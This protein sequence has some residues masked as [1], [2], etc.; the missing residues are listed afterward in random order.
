MT[1]KLEMTP[2]N[3]VIEEFAKGKMVIMVDD[4]DRE[5]EGDLVVATEHLT[6]EDIVFMIKHG[7]GLICASIS[8]E[9]AIELKLPP[10]VEENN[11][12]FSTPFTVTIDLAD[13]NAEGVTAESRAKT[14]RALV[15]SSVTAEQFV[16][17]GHV[18][19]LVANR[20]G[21][22]GR[23]G[24][25]EGSYD[26]ARIAGCAPSGVICEILAE[27]GT[28]ARGEELLVFAK[29]HD[30]PITS[31]Q[32]IIQYRIREEVIARESA[33]S[34]VI[35]EHGEFEVIVFDDDV[36][37]K[38][39]LALVKGDIADLQRSSPLVRVHSE[40]LT[41]DVFGSRRCD[42]GGQ[43][44]A[45]LKEISSAGAG[46]LLYL[47]QEGRGIGL[48]NKLRAYE[49]Q[50]QGRDTVDA[51][52]ELGFEA[53]QRDYAIAASML[54]S[55]GLHSVKLMTNNPK[56]IDAFTKYGIEVSQRIPVVVS[57]DE[58]SKSYLETKKTKLGHLL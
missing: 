51:N 56:K 2:I 55:I 14:M 31:V 46:V 39:H 3:K 53:D 13:I 5:N 52:L 40:C 17:P 54:S 38:E 45:S 9:R 32:E 43:L 10:Q 1:A 23:E 48:L 25:T 30:L 35:M 33:R 12:A 41:G 15:D 7:R 44:E 8:A 4:A 47:R 22:L 49:L 18:F 24:Q 28:M 27:D 36:D 19:P 58:Y 26:L 42:C 11:S 20:A 34:K 57:A 29:K 6:A 21:V 16:R 37:G 50:D